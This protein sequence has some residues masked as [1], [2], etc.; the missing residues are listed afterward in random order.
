MLS[1]LLKDYLPQEK[2][3]RIP[4][5]ACSVPTLLLLRRSYIEEQNYFYKTDKIRMVEDLIKL[6]NSDEC[7][8]I[9]SEQNVVCQLFDSEVPG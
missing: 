7:C 5:S 6:D 4:V 9:S 3:S 8:F 2:W 1:A